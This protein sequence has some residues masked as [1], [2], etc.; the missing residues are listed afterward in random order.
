MSRTKACWHAWSHSSCQTASSCYTLKMNLQ[1]TAQTWKFA[2][3][4][5][6]TTQ[7]PRNQGKKLKRREHT[8]QLLVFLKVPPPAARGSSWGKWKHFYLLNAVINVPLEN[9]NLVVH[10]RS[11]LH[12]HPQ[13]KVVFV[14]HTTLLLDRNVIKSF[15]HSG[16]AKI[17]ISAAL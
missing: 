7:K 9:Q 12:A 8:S 4:C 13:I 10:T 14:I 17:I 6:F 1:P 5:S 3:N 2:L 15:H 16:N 11:S